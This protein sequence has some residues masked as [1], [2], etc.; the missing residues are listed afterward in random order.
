MSRVMRKGRLGFGC[1]RWRDGYRR[2]GCGAVATV[3]LF[4]MPMAACAED[5]R[6]VADVRDLP[7]APGFS[8]GA[9]QGLQAKTA[10]VSGVVLD[11]TEAAVAGATVTLTQEGAA[12]KVLQSE[13]HGVF[14]FTELAAG[15][16]HVTI[17]A[18]GLETFVSS[19]IVVKAGEHKVL[20]EIA[21]PVEAANATVN[22]TVTQDELAEA[23]LKA[24]VQQRVL[25]VLPNFYS[26]Y[27]WNAA[28]LRPKHKFE[29][30]MRSVTDPAVFV[31]SGFVAGV[32]QA[33]GT[34]NKGYGQG[35]AGFG[36][37]YGAVYGDILI[38][39]FIGSALLPSLFHQDP[40]YFY[41]GTGSVKSRVWYAVTRT[42]ITRQDNRRAQLNYSHL[43]GS[44]AAGAISK[45]YHP[46]G[47]D[48][49]ALVERNLL[50]G[51]AAGAGV[52]LIREF[53]LRKVVTK[54]PVYEQGKAVAA[55]EAA[56]R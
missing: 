55:K 26:S 16:Y 45:L 21:L 34:Y 38:G 19:E 47:E 12:E 25:G 14:Q 27:I 11:I 51:T 7:N 4:G 24:E 13:A 56:G 52:N 39:R 10:S 18:R 54:I 41:L 31:V 30:A 17:S 46:G 35:A 5:R 29:L 28:P 6:A 23:Q 22:V 53:L 37:R 1:F 40:R 50:I 49:V 8:G 33:R 2:A 42:V 3:L 43:L 9:E 44:M 20:P 32:E 36:D 15:T 48:G